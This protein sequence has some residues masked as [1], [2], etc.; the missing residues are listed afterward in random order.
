MTNWRSI[1]EAEKTVFLRGILAVEPASYER[2]ARPR[3]ALTLGLV[4]LFLQR[5]IAWTIALAAHVLLAA[6]FLSLYLNVKGEDASSVWASLH[7]GDSGEK[8]KVEEPPKPEPPKEEPKPPEPP[9]PEPPEPP[10][11][12]PKL[13]DPEPAKPAPV[14][15]PAPSPNPVVAPAAET[16]K[17][18]A[19][20]AGASAAG[21]PPKGEVSDKDVEKDPTEAIR[22]RRAGELTRLRG[23]DRKD[24]V[25]V[26]GCYDRVQDVLDRLEIPHTVIGMDRLA[27]YPLP[28]AKILLINCD[29]RYASWTAKGVDAKALLREIDELEELEADLRRRLDRTKDKASI[30]KLN[31][32]LLDTTS[33]LTACRRQLESGVGAARLLENLRAFVEGGGY[34]FTSDWGL[35]L[36]ERVFPGYVRNGGTVGPRTVPIKPRPGKERHALL[37]EVFYAGGK[38]TT[39]VERKFLWEIDSSSYLIRVD[40]TSVETLVE[41]PVLARYPAVAVAFTPD[42]A[43]GKVL[44]VLSH[45]QK[46]ATKQGDFALQ[47]MLLNFMLERARK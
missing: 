36:L 27:T 33:R 15:E 5:V 44:H 43:Q 46:Q 22:R 6:I 10:K 42:K 18:A 2:F 28:G 40:K 37:E 8:G 31:L 38:G 32:L 30:Y 21:T 11:P 34:V 26:E 24:I 9:T 29:N 45:F 17:P 23:G 19:V 41:S 1:D 20:G 13:P 35:T 7:R 4:A 16:P 25:V 47:N 39:A 3:R 14:P 12:E